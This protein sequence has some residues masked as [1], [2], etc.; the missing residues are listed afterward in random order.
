MCYVIF[1]CRSEANAKNLRDSVQDKLAA[2][3]AAKSVQKQLQVAKKK[4]SRLDGKNANIMSIRRER[5]VAVARMAQL[6]REKEDT[7]AQLKVERARYCQ[8]ARYIICI[9]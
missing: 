7:V 9:Y 5:N 8:H 2:Q 1:R 6:E 4:L 3:A